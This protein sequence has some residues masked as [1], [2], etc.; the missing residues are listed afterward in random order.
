MVNSARH[1]RWITWQELLTIRLARV[2]ECHS[3]LDGV[4]H[5]VCIDRHHMP[6][7]LH[8]ELQHP[9]HL[10]SPSRFRAIPAILAQRH[11]FT[12]TICI[13]FSLHNIHIH[14]SIWGL[15]ADFF[16]C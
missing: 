2:Y 11:P 9:L 10:S 16:L 14:H 7:L 13:A 5:F 15:E 6:L 1:I 3:T 12:I 4:Y 8:P